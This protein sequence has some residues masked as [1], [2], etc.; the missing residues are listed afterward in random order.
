M[1]NNDSKLIKF[2]NYN[3]FKFSQYNNLKFNKYNQ[4]KF[5]KFNKY[6][7][8]KINN[9]LINSNRTRTRTLII[10]IWNKW[11]LKNA[12]LKLTEIKIMHWKIK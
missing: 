7:N 4:L 1:Y 11:I 12:K 8:Y 6:N 10:I 3:H 2:H 5:N 9:K